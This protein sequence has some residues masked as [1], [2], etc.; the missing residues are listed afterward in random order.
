MVQQQSVTR[1]IKTFV[2]LGFG[3]VILLAYLSLGAV[4]LPLSDIINTLMDALLHGEDYAREQHPRVVAILFY[5]RGPRA[6][7]AILAGGGLALAGAAMQGLFKNPMASPDIMG[8]SA[9]SSLGAVVAI[10]FGLAAYHPLVIPGFSIVGGLLTASF[11]FAL[12]GRAGVMQLLFL[13]LAGLAV[14]SL[15][16]GAVSAVLMFSQEYEISQFIFW[17][18]GGLEGRMWQHILWPA[19][20]ILVVGYLTFRLGQPLNV[21]SLG[22]ENA[23]GMGLDVQ[24]IKFRV[25]LYTA[26]LTSLAIS[27]AGPIGFV[28]LMVPHFVRMIMGPDH[29][30]LLPLSMFVGATFVL[31]CDLLGRWLIAPYEIRVGVITSIVG[32]TYFVFLIMRYYRMGRLMS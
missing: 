11:V 15:L 8:I 24:S 6:V 29:R 9:G 25:L 10:T 5:I 14:S 32:G 26:L 16:G 22:E 21:L 23:H 1:G 12:A 3:L 28:G 13:I 17:T 20:L 19:P 4:S 7:A 30:V 27:M 31:F 2:L 18:M